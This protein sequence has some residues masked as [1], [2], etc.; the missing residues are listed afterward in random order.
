MSAV[1]SEGGRRRAIRILGSMPDMRNKEMCEQEKEDARG[2]GSETKG[3][4][5][6]LG[7]WGWMYACEE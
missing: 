3:K 1:L 5:L 6:V 2:R 7:R 4:G